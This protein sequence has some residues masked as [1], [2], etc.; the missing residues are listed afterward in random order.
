VENG[1]GALNF[2]ARGRRRR[3]RWEAWCLWGR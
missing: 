1:I 3:A 2:D